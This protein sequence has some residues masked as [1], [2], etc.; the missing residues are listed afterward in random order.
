MNHI[1]S[2]SRWAGICLAL[3]ALSACGGSDGGD[4]AGP[5]LTRYAGTWKSP[6]MTINNRVSGQ[7]L[8]EIRGNATTDTNLSG[9]RIVRLFNN[10]HC[11]GAPANESY[12]LL[13][14][15]AGGAR[16]TASGEASMVMFHL[17]SSNARDPA[18]PEPYGELMLL[19]DGRLYLGNRANIAG[20]GYPVDVDLSM[21]WTR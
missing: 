19:V 2:G 15:A 13:S 8:L 21:P 1:L 18:A 17:R 12:H 4:A 9:L 14:G 10:L 11:A 7:T 16:Q 5:S 3:A 6:C 20:D